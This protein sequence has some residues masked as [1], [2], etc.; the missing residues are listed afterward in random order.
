[1]QKLLV[2]SVLTLMSV[3]T[4]QAQNIFL[5]GYAVYAFDDRFDTY[6]S[7]TQ[8][9]EGKIKGGLQWG[10]G[11]EY[12]P[13]DEMGVELIYFRQDTEVPVQFYLD[14]P[15]NRTLDLGLKYILLSGNRYFKPGGKIDPY[16]SLMFGMAIYKNKSPETGEPT[17]ATKFAWGARLGTNIWVSEKVGLKIQAQ[18]LSSVQSLGG[19]FYLGTGGAGAGV[20]TYSTLYQFGLGGGLVLKV[21]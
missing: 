5:N 14:G 17:S 18:I 11:L 16:A 7:N 2:A 15:R 3:V 8:Y 6:Y 4:S 1:M 20:S 10:G 13:A 19:G 12:K 21:K 9:I